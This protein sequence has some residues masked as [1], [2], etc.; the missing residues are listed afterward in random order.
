VTIEGKN[1]KKAVFSTPALTLDLRALPFSDDTCVSDPVITLKAEKLADRDLLG[2]SITAEF[3]LDEGQAVWFV[4]RE[5]GDFA[6]QSDEHQKVANP[7]TQRAEQLGVPIEELTEA[8]SKLRPK[9]NP[10][11][12]KVS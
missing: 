6:Y 9:E 7:G 8:S 3:E 2:E 12:S 5:V 10:I 1:S 11:L 4:F